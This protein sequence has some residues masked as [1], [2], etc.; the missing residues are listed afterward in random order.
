MIGAGA[1]VG[2]C[3]EV[4]GEEFHVMNCGGR[5]GWIGVMCLRVPVSA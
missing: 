2:F 4:V 5:S 1:L 3:V